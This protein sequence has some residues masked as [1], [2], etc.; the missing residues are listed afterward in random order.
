MIENNLTIFI[1]EIES[2]ETILIFDIHYHPS[3]IRI[4]VVVSTFRAILKT[5]KLPTNVIGVYIITHLS[6]GFLYDKVGPTQVTT[7]IVAWEDSLTFFSSEHINNTYM[8]IWMHLRGETR[9]WRPLLEREREREMLR[10]T[11]FVNIG[12]DYYWFITIK[13][14]TMKS[15]TS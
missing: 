1:D 3:V 5:F 4:S 13:K 2:Q 11:I 7:F 15:K 10:S 8:Y 6:L 9:N 14:K 12:L